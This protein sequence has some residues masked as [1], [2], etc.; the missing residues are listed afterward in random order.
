MCQCVS[1]CV[2]EGERVR[3]GGREGACDKFPNSLITEPF[4][5]AAL[6]WPG[7]MLPHHSS[8]CMPD[9]GAPYVMPFTLP[10]MLRITM[11]FFMNVLLSHNL[12]AFIS[13]TYSYKG[14]S[15]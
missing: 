5:V 3:D 7:A 2:R 13:N 8:F 1:Q 4:T 6:L 14:A 15:T 12:S 9:T 10:C 11:T